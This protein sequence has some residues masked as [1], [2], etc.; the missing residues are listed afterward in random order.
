MILGR[1]GKGYCKK[2]GCQN[3]WLGCFSAFNT[4][5]NEVKNKI[6]NITYL[7]TA[8]AL[9]AVDNKIPTVSNVVKTTDSNT[10]ISKI[11]FVK[12]RF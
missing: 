2:I 12:N 11:E 8:T 4:R 5:M 10:E 6:T 1:L 7:A 9:T 3:F